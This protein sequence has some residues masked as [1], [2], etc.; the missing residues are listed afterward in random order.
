MLHTPI[1][2]RPG[3]SSQSR[4]QFWYEWLACSC[5]TSAAASFFLNLSVCV[6]LH[7]C[8]WGGGTWVRVWVCAWRCRCVFM[9]CASGAEPPLTHSHTDVSQMRCATSDV[10]RRQ[11]RVVG[12]VPTGPTGTCAHQ[13]IPPLPPPQHTVLSQSICNNCTALQAW[14]S[15]ESGRWLLTQLVTSTACVLRP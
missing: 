14:H 1:V 9:C 12:P 4:T 2:H 11:A 7:V 13:R 6:W 3:C 5:A 10:P 15:N 8:V